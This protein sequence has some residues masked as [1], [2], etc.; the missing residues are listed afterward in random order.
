MANR[1]AMYESVVTHQRFQPVG[2]RLRYSVYSVLFDL[3]EIDGLAKRIPIL[4]RNRFN[5]VSFHDRDFGPRDGSDLRAWFDDEAAAFGV[6]LTGGRVEL[7]AFPRILGYTFNPIT[8]WFGHDAADGLRFVMYEVHN[9]FGQEHRYGFA[10]PGDT[11]GSRLP[12]HTTAKRF[13]VSPFMD[14][15]GVYRMRLSPPTDRY[16]L[17][18]EYLDDDGERLL[19]AAQHGRRTELTTWSLLRQFLT[20]PLLTLKVIGGIHYEAIKLW[21]KGAKYRSVP[22][23]LPVTT[24]RAVVDPEMATTAS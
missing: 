15:T 24:E 19:T 22:D 12:P 1:S 21:I 3:D 17:T 16:G 11:D 10:V 20:K 23:P 5:L 18:I 4:S 2:H 9:T 13:H 8:V 6:D 7:L 14:R